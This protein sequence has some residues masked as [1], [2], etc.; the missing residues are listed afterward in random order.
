MLQN[1]VLKRCK[2]QVLLLYTAQLQSL[3]PTSIIKLIKFSHYNNLLKLNLL[4]YINKIF[5]ASGGNADLPSSNISMTSVSRNKATLALEYLKW[6]F[7][8]PKSPKTL[9]R[10]C[11]M[12]SR[13]HWLCSRNNLL[14]ELTRMEENQR[15]QERETERMNDKEEQQ[16]LSRAHLL[17]RL[18][19][20]PNVHVKLSRWSS[21]R[22]TATCHTAVADN[23]LV[24]HSTLC[25][26]TR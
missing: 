17:E 22:V 1:I 23:S 26:Y 14:L 21:C 11:L 15:I 25:F 7:Q 2:S 12:P 10:V 9:N 13:L 20:M 6:M 3:L 8:Q 19:L 16:K 24:T 18:A 4:I 5:Y